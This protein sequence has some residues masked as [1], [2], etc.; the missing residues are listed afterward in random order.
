MF[1]KNVFHSENTCSRLAIAKKAASDQENATQPFVL[2]Q[3]RKLKQMHGRCGTVRYA[4][5][6]F[7]EERVPLR[8]G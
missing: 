7:S 4:Q 8:N 1:A 5:A 2:D 6:I 3:S